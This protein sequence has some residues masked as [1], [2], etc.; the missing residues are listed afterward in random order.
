MVGGLCDFDLGG[1]HQNSF[2]GGLNGAFLHKS[3]KQPKISTRF[4][5]AAVLVK[6]EV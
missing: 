5:I 3:V 1:R 4:N 6:V 2:L